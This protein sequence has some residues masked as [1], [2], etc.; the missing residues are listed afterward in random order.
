MGFNS[1]FKGLTS[2]DSTGAENRPV[3]NNY[4]PYVTRNVCVCK[5]LF[6]RRILKTQ[7]L[8]WY[9]FQLNP[10]SSKVVKYRCRATIQASHIS[11]VLKTET[12]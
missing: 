7:F 2:T 5:S 10:F 6:T 1:G 8:P 12:T 11:F 3:C 4:F 9:I